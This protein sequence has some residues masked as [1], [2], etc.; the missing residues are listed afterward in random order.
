MN[1]VGSREKNGRE[2]AQGWALRRFFPTTKNE[3]KP[4]QNTVLQACGE[5]Y[6]RVRAANSSQM[7]SNIKIR[8]KDKIPCAG[9]WR[10][11]CRRSGCEFVEDL[12][13]EEGA[14]A[15]PCRHCCNGSELHYRGYMRL[16]SS[17]EPRIGFVAGRT[18]PAQQDSLLVSTSI[19][20]PAEAPATPPAAA[21]APRP[22]TPEP[23]AAKEEAQ[24]P[25]RN[26]APSLLAR[27]TRRT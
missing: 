25:K 15:P 10:N 14:P 16:V 21:L 3:K 13:L 17:N 4:K 8:T 23:V 18:Y 6:A 11:E 1:R 22:R 7:T 5:T 9:L 19:S 2:T 24:T 27:L 26:P 12:L 20:P